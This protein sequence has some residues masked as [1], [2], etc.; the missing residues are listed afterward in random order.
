MEIFKEII[1]FAATI[2]GTTI[3][4]PQ[5]YKSIKTKSV[6]DISWGMLVLYFLNC[7]LWMIYGFLILAIPL[8]LTN[9]IALCISILQIT[10]KIRYK[11]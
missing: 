8:I 7:L 5:I 10:L 9:G 4:L 11:D 3:M 1:G 2:V 6:S